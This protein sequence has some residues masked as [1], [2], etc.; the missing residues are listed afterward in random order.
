MNIKKNLWGIFF[1]VAAALVIVNQL[2]F[3]IGIGSWSLIFTVTLIPI[4]VYGIIHRNFF[5]IFFAIAFLLIVF[6]ETLHIERLVPWTVLTAALFLSIGFSVLFKPKYRWCHSKSIDWDSSHSYEKSYTKHETFD[7]VEGNEINCR[8]SLAGSSKYLRSDSL[9]TGHFECSLGSLKV[10]FDQVT[11]HPDGATAFIDC[12]LGNVELFIPRTWN[13]NLNLDTALGSVQE[14][15]HVVSTGGAP[16]L[17][18][19]GS[20]SLGAVEIRYI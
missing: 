6:A 15:G 16:R 13:V 8:I 19:T 12:S 9:R 18:I 2:D 14:H 5:N 11:L 10:Y 3:F 4:L 1:I 7:N 20:V 17:T